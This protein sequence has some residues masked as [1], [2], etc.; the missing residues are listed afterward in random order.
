MNDAIYW[1]VAWGAVAIAAAAIAGIL[2]GY[3]NRDYSFWMAWSF[4]FPPMV[5]FLLLLPNYIGERPR[6]PKL[7]EDDRHLY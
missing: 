3:K 6:R 1:I 2:A 4:I 5:L 7:D